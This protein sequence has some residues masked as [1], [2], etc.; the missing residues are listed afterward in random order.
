MVIGILFSGIIVGLIAT[1]STLAMGL[2]VWA[3]VLL[4][5][6]SGIIGSIG[7]ISVVISR[8]RFRSPKATGKLVPSIR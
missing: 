8:E 4:Y 6:I 2:P 3:A 7:F 1:I 5:P